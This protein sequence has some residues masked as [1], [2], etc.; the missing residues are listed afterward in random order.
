MI[1]SRITIL[2]QL[3]SFLI[4]AH[5]AKVV[6][7]GACTDNFGSI[8]PVDCGTLLVPLDYTVA[9][10]ETY[11]LDLLRVPATVQPAMGSIVLNFGGPGEVGRATLSGY[12]TLLQA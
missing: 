11:T 6:Q 1:L 12:A 4:A 9:S 3:S 2:I 10:N 8:L 5:A 7:W